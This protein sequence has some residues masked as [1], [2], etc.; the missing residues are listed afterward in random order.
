MLMRFT[1][2]NNRLIGAG[3]VALLLGAG[4]AVA[5]DLSLFEPVD[6]AEAVN[7]P[8]QRPGPGASASATDPEFTLVGS[9]RI[10]NKVK[11]TLRTRSGELVVV[12]GTPD[13]T[14]PIPGFG[15]YT[16]D[17]SRAR[18]V[19]ITL[20]AGVGCV[21][22]TER[23]VSCEN[24]NTASLSLATAAPLVVVERNNQAGETNST[25]NAE[26]ENETAD[27]DASNPFAAALR[28]AAANANEAPEDVVNRRAD[29]QRF[30]MRRINPEDV[31]EGM[32]LVRTPFG[33]RLVQQ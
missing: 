8:V 32:R 30:Q 26:N 27:Q 2:L 20:P 5:Q 4:Q 6:N 22:F 31:P 25:E 3:A 13:S 17:N 9:S 23:G 7:N 21:E 18:S 16:L 19:S 11:T 29:S 24:Q 28:A 10:G 14:M 1:I 33:D 12:A 15:G